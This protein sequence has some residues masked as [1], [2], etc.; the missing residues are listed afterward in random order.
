MSGE[1]D[2]LERRPAFRRGPRALIAL[3]AGLTLGLTACASIDPPSAPA[4]IAPTPVPRPVSAEKPNPERKRLIDAFGGVYSA[5]ATQTYLDGVLTK[6]A[7]PSDATGPS[8]HVTVLNSPIVNAFS[9]PSGDI[10]VTRGLL[11]LADDTSEIAA[12]MAHEIGHITARH[13]AQRA[14]FEKTTALFTKVNTQLLAQRQAQ[15]E[16]EARSKLAIASFSRQQEFEADQIGIKT[17]AKAGYD[18]YA[19]ARFLTALGEWSALRASVS[20]AGSADRP[21]MMATHPSTP[22]R[23]AQATEAARQ[24]GPPGT[25]ETG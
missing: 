10:F 5:P 21:D 15:D 22:E 24:F 19:A 14:E 11:A 23:V 2:H 4:S 13:A 25:G 18:P 6:I 20:G 3:I 12:I 7:P 9:L 1:P 17:I 8:Y 16:A